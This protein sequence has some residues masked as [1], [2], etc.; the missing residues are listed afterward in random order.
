VPVELTVPDASDT[1]D[2]STD[3]FTKEDTVSI[4]KSKLRTGT[5]SFEL[6]MIEIFKE[7]ALGSTTELIIIGLIVI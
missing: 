1:T 5:I 6:G 2:V 4:S 3:A 7:V